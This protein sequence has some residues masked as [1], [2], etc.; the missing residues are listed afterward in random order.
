LG[1]SPKNPEVLLKYPGGLHSYLERQVML[2]KPRTVDKVYV[3]AQYLEMD[4]KKEQPNSS[5]Q[6]DHQGTSMEGK[7]KW[8]GKDMKTTATTHQ[9]KDPNNHCNHCNVD[10]HIEDKYWKPHPL[11]NSKNRKKESKKKNMLVV[12]SGNQIESNTDVDENIIYTT[13][14][15][16]NLSSLLPKKEKEMTKHFHIK[17]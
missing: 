17:I 14:Q 16:V 7:K 5:K 13:T 9:Y 4:R 12:D 8:K 10:P 11:L 6:K 2:F 15:E 1:I 3:Q